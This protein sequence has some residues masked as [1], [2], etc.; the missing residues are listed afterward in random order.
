M[1]KKFLYYRQPIKAI[2]VSSYIPRKCG[3]ATYT[4]DLTNDINQLNPYAL[5]E[6]LAI[7]R[8][9]DNLSYPWEVKFKINQNDLESY[10]QAANYVNQSETDLVV[11]EHEFGL[12]GG[13][14]GDYIISFT[15][16]IKK[17]LIITFHTIIDDPANNYGIVQKRL[18]D[19]AE[20][21]VVMINDSANKLKEKYQVPEE[22]IAVIPHG[23]PD[24]PYGAG[25]HF[26]RKKRLKGK[27]VLGN[28]NLLSEQKGI[29]Y[30]LRAVAQI[31]QQYPNVVYLVIGQ[32][33]PVVLEKFGEKYRRFLKK[34]ARRLGIEDKV[35]FVNEYLSLN[36]LLE[37]LQ[38]ID[39]YV[40]PYLNPEQSSSGALAYAI[41]SG[42]SCIS[43]PYL[44]AQENL[45]DDRGILVPF[46]NSEAI[47]EAV[48][49]LL[50]NPQKRLNMEKRAYQHGRLMT[51]TNVAL[52]H[53]DLFQTILDLKKS[54]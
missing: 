9:E 11:L 3:I 36:E 8:P 7:N 25:E 1:T 24:L 17:P 26:K 10:I 37:W 42:K 15:E 21:I 16:V 23:I 19:R 13:Q 22:K 38:A 35:H 18:A 20:A 54:T 44:Y 32:T 2:Y 12:Y 40:T 48:L 14:G 28:I 50:A 27:I 47:A 49:E 33:H 34:E 51:W 39:F 5:A 41:G 6:I 29:E 52:Q 53:L 31:A 43:T 46:K 45:S 30:A 4:K